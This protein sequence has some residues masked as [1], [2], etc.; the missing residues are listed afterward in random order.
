MNTHDDR[1]MGRLYMRLLPIQIVLVIIAGVNNIIDSAFAGNLIGAEAMAVVG[2]FFPVLNLINSINVLFSGGAQI[3]CGKYLGK[4]MVEKTKSIFTID[5]LMV[6]VITAVLI[7]I[8]EVIPESVASLL[9]AKGAYVPALASYIRGFVIGL[10]PLMLGTQL[11]AFLQIEKKEK[12]TY[13]AIGGMLFANIFFNWLFI[14][15]LGM[16]L[17]GLGLA[18]SIS[19]FVF[20]FVQMAYYFTGKAIISFSISSIRRLD[21]RDILKN[22]FPPA[23]SQFCILLRL[24]I[25][26]YLV[27]DNVGSDGLAALSAVMTFGNLYWSVSAGV[28]SAVTMLASVHTG[29][30][31]RE[32][33]K[34]LMRVFFKRGILLVTLASLVYMALSIPL[35]NIFFHDPSTPVYSMTCLGFL[36]FPISCPFSA[37][38][39]G[40]MNYIHCLGTNEGFVR[41]SSFFDGVIGMVVFSAILIP[42]FGMPGTWIA[43]IGSGVMLC[44]IIFG[45]IVYKNGRFPRTFEDMMCFPSDFG[46][47]E[48]NR[49]DMTI[50]DV[51]EAMTVSVGVSGFCRDHGSDLKTANRASLSVEELVN[52]II[53]HGFTDKKKH[54]ID[55]S[56]TYI[57][58]TYI[59][60]I[61]D[62]C[63]AFN[64][65]E[66]AE[67]FDPEDKTHN[68]G[69]RLISGIAQEMKYHNSF[70]LN[71]LTIVIRDEG[72]NIAENV[73]L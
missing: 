43:Q 33:L 29:E 3:M 19:N 41:F 42:V 38:L 5:M 35:T 49:M 4:Q 25:V 21:L 27:R 72:L 22:G 15:Q 9:G 73:A 1:M 60:T 59:L 7:T 17:F 63:K 50:H 54:H 65:K 53:K 67:L 26:N 31:D 70:G 34:S 44:L 62:D 69:L 56:V 64:P 37:I 51:E 66:A 20:F 47:G 58:E 68:I 52:N 13:T 61:K 12:L 30:E 18:T 24:V 6:T 36:L 2:L 40:Y 45:F 23:I 55:M 57:N 14:S 16:G 8:C 11:T 10:I 46:A 48:G 32:G 28:T 71:I 39:V